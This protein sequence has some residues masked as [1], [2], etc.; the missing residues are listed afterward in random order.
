MTRTGWSGLLCLMTALLGIG[1][2]AAI[3][4]AGNFDLSV[5]VAVASVMPLAV[6][7]AQP[8]P[9]PRPTV[10]VDVRPTYERQQLINT[11]VMCGQC[12]ALGHLWEMDYDP[13]L[14]HV[15]KAHRH[16]AGQPLEAA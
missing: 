5:I 16:E 6:R 8:S 11:Q 10:H 4:L 3:A 7:M 14:G 13:M 12:A 9:R 2:T 1:I 15:C